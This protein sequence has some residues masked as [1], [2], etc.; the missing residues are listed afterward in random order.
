M[1]TLQDELQFN[2]HKIEQYEHMLQTERQRIREL[3][4]ELQTTNEKLH[5]QTET[6]VNLMAKQDNQQELV[7][8]E[9]LQSELQKSNALA[10]QQVTLQVSSVFLQGWMSWGNGGSYML[11]W[12]HEAQA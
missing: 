12:L 11:S 2:N 6:N 1:E 9:H 3:E 5:F 8:L 4:Q 7:T 10:E